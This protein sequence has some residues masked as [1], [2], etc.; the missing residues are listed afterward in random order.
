MAVEAE[1]IVNISLYNT[2]ERLA[3]LLVL[4]AEE[5]PQNEQ[6]YIEIPFNNEELAT[7]VG[8][9]RNSVFNA[10]SVFQKQ[11]L[12]HKGRGRLVIADLP[13]LKEYV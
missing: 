9:C 10:L 12:I 6:G 11:K 4:L 2:A 5:F 3:A 8:A 13:R 1:E 7:M